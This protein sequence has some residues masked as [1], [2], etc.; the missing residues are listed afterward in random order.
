M[1]HMPSYDACP[2]PPVESGFL[3]VESGSE[4][5]PYLGRELRASRS[6][7]RTGG[8]ALNVIGRAK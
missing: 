3:P 8:M 1:I 4:G 5:L 7:Q 2:G 6:C